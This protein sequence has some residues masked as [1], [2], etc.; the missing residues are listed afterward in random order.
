MATHKIVIFNNYILKY[1]KEP[2]LLV[3]ESNKFRKFIT[4]KSKKDVSEFVVNHIQTTY[5]KELETSPYAK[6]CKL[7]SEYP[8]YNESMDSIMR[9][10]AIQTPIYRLMLE[11]LESNTRRMILR[12]PQN[13]MVDITKQWQNDRIRILGEEIVKYSELLLMLSAMVNNSLKF[14]NDNPAL[15]LRVLGHEVMQLFYIDTKTIINPFKYMT[16]LSDTKLFSKAFNSEENTILQSFNDPC[17]FNSFTNKG[18]TRINIATRYDILQMCNIKHNFPFSQQE[19]IY[20]IGAL[21]LNILGATNENINLPTNGTVYISYT[22]DSM[23]TLQIKQ[24]ARTREELLD[25]D[26]INQFSLMH[27]FLLRTLGDEGLRYLTEFEE[28]RLI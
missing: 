19:M 6:F 5:Q 22:T 4:Q 7:D 16:F 28:A 10:Y 27:L 15:A 14:N 13:E 8:S 20:L 12:T 2:I 21:A 17:V 18:S 9:I 24:Y 11:L 1:N 23:E 3:N 25:A 26:I